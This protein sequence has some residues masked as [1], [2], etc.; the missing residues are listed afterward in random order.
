[1][2]LLN[3]GVVF[4][5]AQANN[6]LTTTNLSRFQVSAPSVLYPKIDSDFSTKI[7]VWSR[8]ELVTMKK[9]L[10]GEHPMKFYDWYRQLIR[11]SK[12]R[13]LIIVGTL[14]YLLSPIDL[15]PDFIPLIGQVDDVVVLTLLI[16]EVS[17]MLSERIR[18]SKNKN[19]PEVADASQNTTG[20]A[21]SV[22]VNA[23][24]VD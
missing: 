10:R 9:Q 17:Q 3:A 8:V 7:S 22:D 14:L 1:L 12:Y 13:W 21:S 15:L 11:N 5:F 20:D 18:S 19:S 6:L 4:C 24:H 16:S 2:K 23:V